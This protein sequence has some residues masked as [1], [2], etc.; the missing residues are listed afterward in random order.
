MRNTFGEELLDWLIVLDCNH[1]EARYGFPASL[2]DPMM[3]RVRTEPRE[4]AECR[5][6]RTVTYA[7]LYDMAVWEAARDARWDAEHLRSNAH[8]WGHCLCNA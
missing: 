1:V 5:A 7:G 6:E 4:C 8:A 3:A 2:G